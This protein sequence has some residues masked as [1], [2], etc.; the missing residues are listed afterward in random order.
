MDDDPVPHLHLTTRLYPLSAYFHPPILDLNGRDAACFVKPD[1]P[2]ELVD[3][4]ET[5]IVLE[6]D[7]QTES[8]NNTP[9]SGFY[10]AWNIST[11]F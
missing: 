9:R 5:N 3:T 2:K 10:K 6:L 1:C 8:W 4:H 11:G 7:N